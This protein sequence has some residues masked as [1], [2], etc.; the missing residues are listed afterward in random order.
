VSDSQS[1]HLTLQILMC[2]SWTKLITK[3]GPKFNK[4]LERFKEISLPQVAGQY[5]ELRQRVVGAKLELFK[6]QRFNP[7]SDYPLSLENTDP[8][9]SY[10]A[11]S[12]EFLS[13]SWA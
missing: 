6:N 5:A 12:D 7:L 11:G 8:Q 2:R 13:Q 4:V 3:S 1:K 9:Y 10:Q